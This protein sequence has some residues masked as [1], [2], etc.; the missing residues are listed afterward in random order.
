MAKIAAIVLAAGRSQRM[1]R[2]KPLLPLAGKPAIRWCL[3][4]LAAAGLREIV[5][6][7]GAAGTEIAATVADH[8]PTLAWNLEPDSDMAGSLRIGLAQVSPEVEA[9]L[10]CPADYP[11]VAPATVHCLLAEQRQHPD[12]IIIPTHQ[13]RK[14]HPVLFPHSILAELAE[15][16]T[17]RD[18]VRRDP[19]RLRLL[20]VDDEAILLDMDTP[21]D[22]QLLQDRLARK[23]AAAPETVT[24]A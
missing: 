7:L 1:G 4:Y 3:G 5:L 21:S 19:R 17:L 18:L 2:S 16:P 23:L 11:L 15:L 9:L 14:G 20:E 13:G 22:Y 8:Q 10:I 6:V 24:L 12:R